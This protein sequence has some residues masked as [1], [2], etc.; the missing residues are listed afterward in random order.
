MNP[1]NDL[2][3]PANILWFIAGMLSVQ[4]WQRIKCKWKGHYHP[5]PDGKPY[6]MK[7]LNW[8]YVWTTLVML[9]I[10]AVGLHAEQLAKDTAV[11][12]YQFNRALV[13][14]REINNEDRALRL[15]WEQAT[16]KRVSSL[17]NPP[18]GV[19]STIDP[20][21]IQYKDY[22]DREYFRSIRDIDKRRA[23]N[24]DRR[25]LPENQYP[26]PTCG[27]QLAGIK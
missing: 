14:S 17:I 19:D 5:R 12:Q 18:P 15:E 22:V 26:E 3:S 1:L 20:D 24:D 10:V 2:L 25:S 23:A 16:L 13:A 9:I 8:F 6:P 21:Y 4:A 7:K 27:K 11:C